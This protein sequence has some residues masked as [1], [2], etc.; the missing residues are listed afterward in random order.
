M[1][2]IMANCIL[3]HVLWTIWKEETQ[4]HTQHN[5]FPVLTFSS[6]R[7]RQYIPGLWELTSK[8][9]Q[10]FNHCS[11]E[12]TL[13]KSF[14]NATQKCGKFWREVLMLLV[15][16]FHGYDRLDMKYISPMTLLL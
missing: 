11:A 16:L 2:V 3:V 15:V 5:I 8:F 12:C 10:P 14:N 4:N 7:L 6:M 9:A 1:C 13:F